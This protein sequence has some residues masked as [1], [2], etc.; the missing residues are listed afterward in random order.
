M[1]GQLPL[2]QGTSRPDPSPPVRLGITLATEARGTPADPSP[3]VSGV[4]GQS[5][6]LCGASG[7]PVP[8]F[9]GLRAAGVP[10]SA[11][12]PPP[13]EGQHPALPLVAETAEPQGSGRVEA[14]L[15]GV[16]PTAQGSQ[17]EPGPEPGGASGRVCDPGP[18]CPLSLGSCFCKAGG[19]LPLRAGV[20]TAAGRERPA[21]WAGALRSRGRRGGWSRAEVAE[22][23]KR[24]HAWGRG[25]GDQPG[26]GA[27]VQEDPA[28]LQTCLL[29]RWAR[30]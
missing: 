15:W 9:G 24:Q 16:V 29:G 22:A 18:V 21:G 17:T 7:P 13:P 10:G 2:S 19:L 12:A 8:G 23:L 3:R 30:T 1:K 6:G 20:G 4:R 27:G 25:W 11:A 5:T 14:L 26:L 28:C